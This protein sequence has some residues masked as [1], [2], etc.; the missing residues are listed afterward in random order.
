[1][2]MQAQLS[3]LRYWSSTFKKM[4]LIQPYSAASERPQN[5]LEDYVE[6]YIA[7]KFKFQSFLK[8]NWVILRHNW[9]EYR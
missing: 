8:H 9:K 4:L 3:E 7:K 2:Y 5:S 6:A 1:M